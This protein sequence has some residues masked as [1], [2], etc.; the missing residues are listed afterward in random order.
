MRLLTALL[1]CL[2]ATA[3]YANDTESLAKRI[4][5]GRAIYM[6]HCQ[7][8]HLAGVAN[9]PKVHDQEEWNRRWAAASVIARKQHP[10]LSEK[11]LDAA[12]MKVLIKIGHKGKNLM[13]AGA[14]CQK[15]T[16]DQY[17][18]AILYMMSPKEK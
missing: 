10:H 14:L 8:C 6:Q 15:C 2:L 13:P 5:K 17:R 4:E 3:I 7:T 9:A 18:N 11:D 1:C 16:N 12:T